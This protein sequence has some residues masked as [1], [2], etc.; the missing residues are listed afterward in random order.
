HRDGPRLDIA[1]LFGLIGAVVVA[2]TYIALTGHRPT[3]LVQAMLLAVI[4]VPFWLVRLVGH[5]QPVPRWLRWVALGGLLVL[6]GLWLGAEVLSPMVLNLPLLAYFGF[7]G[8]YAANA[9]LR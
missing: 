4:T 8:L 6:W 9:F 7:I 3:W 5:L 1:M 2:Q